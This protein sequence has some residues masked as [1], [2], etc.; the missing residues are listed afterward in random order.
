MAITPYRPISWNNDEPLFT[1]KL[2][3]MTSNDQWLFE[4][5]PRAYYNAYNVKKTSGIKIAAGL[6]GFNPNGTPREHHIVNFG[7]F[8][9]P[10]ARPII[11]TSLGHDGEVRLHYGIKGIGTKFPDHRGF[12]FLGSVDHYNQKLNKM[13]RRYY[14]HWIAISY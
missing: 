5:A 11:A 10:G 7:T 6:A 4:N 14:L 8:F 9:T 12:E 2:N 13:Q 3:Q 1:D